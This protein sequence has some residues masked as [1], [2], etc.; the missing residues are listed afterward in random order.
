MEQPAIKLKLSRPIKTYG[1]SGPRDV[2]PAFD[3]DGYAIGDEYSLA[4]RLAIQRD[5]DV[6]GVCTNL[7]W[8]VANTLAC[9]DGPWIWLDPD[10]RAVRI[11]ATLGDVSAEATK[12]CGSC[13]LVRECA[14]RLFGVDMDSGSDSEL[15]FVYRSGTSL[16]MY[17]ESSPFNVELF[18]LV[19]QPSPWPTIG[20]E[21]VLTSPEGPSGS[22]FPWFGGSTRLVQAD[23]ASPACLAQIK[24][25]MEQCQQ[26]HPYCHRDPSKEVKAR[27]P[28]R[29]VYVGTSNET[30]RLDEVDVRDPPAYIALSYSWGHT[31]RLVCTGDNHDLLRT[32][33]PYDKLPKTLQDAIT[34]TRD[35]GISYIWIDGLCIKQSDAA[36][37][38]SESANM[39]SIYG[40]ACLTITATSSSD[41]DDGCFSNR[42]QA[43][44]VEITE[45]GGHETI[46]HARK[47]INHWVW[48]WG[49]S[50]VFDQA[51]RNYDVFD[52]SNR[53]HDNF[54]P[55]AMYPLMQRGWCFQERM[56]SRRILHYTVDELVWECL[57]MTSCECGT[58]D[59]FVWSSILQE[60]RY[61]AGIPPDIEVKCDLLDRARE[62]ERRMR[63]SGS[64][65][66][67]HNLP[68]FIKN[69][70]ALVHV[71]AGAGDRPVGERSLRTLLFRTSKQQRWYDL[72]QQYS[73]KALTKNTDA[74]PALSGL[75]QCWAGH[76][77]LGE[78]VAGLWRRDL[79]AG[80]LW[81]CTD[82]STS[83]G[84]ST[85]YLAPSW[86]WACAPACSEESL[87]G[88]IKLRGRPVE[89][90]VRESDRSWSHV[91]LD[92]KAYGY[93]TTLLE[94]PGAPFLPDCRPECLRLDGRP[95]YHLWF[96]TDIVNT[97]TMQGFQRALVLRKHENG[98]YSRIGIRQNCS[99]TS[100]FEEHGHEPPEIEMT[101]V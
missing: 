2:L 76:G 77:D 55:I 42:T 23:A 1:P 89:A 65:D 100:W 40:N 38:E 41:C 19:G 50:N 7:D 5:P 52:Q 13:L 37:W 75:A 78:Y 63:L 8:H 9:G 22:A 54:S 97:Q 81:K 6:C 29:L 94:T 98:T 14:V 44:D 43:V 30:V 71:A 45:V 34:I 64:R 24:T 49:N 10:R 4:R 31:R 99:E 87:L 18:T 3:S 59:R 72:V 73:R 74:L 93:N 95:V 101:I 88:S 56:L 48:D 79:L 60:R 36:D 15:Q 61:A 62:M 96:C 11:V 80:L 70:I 21:V 91:G 69:D 32:N 66:M 33:I 67:L 51:T 83:D 20:S 47:T 46:L 26:E 16:N 84:R 90:L 25:W 57:G 92:I 27:P 86:S 28:K 85:A 12:G 35:L 53:K 58:L 82:Y 39:A 68:T 17:L